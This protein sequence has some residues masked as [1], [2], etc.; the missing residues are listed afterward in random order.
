M[1]KNQRR[2][3]WICLSLAAVT[4]AVYGQALRCQF[5]TFDDQAYV[6]ENRH[7]LT[8]LT[9]ADIGWAFRSVTAG[10]WHPVTMLSHMLDCQIYGLRPWGHHLTSILLH[11][12]N[13]VL[14]F[15]L[16]ARMTGA[17]WPSACVAALFGV[18]PAHVESVAWVAERKDVLCAFFCLLA[19][20]AY[21]NA[22]TSSSKYRYGWVTALLALA[23]MSKPMAVTL[24]FVLLLLDYWPLERARGP[25]WPAWRRLATEKWPLLALSA[26][27]CGVT[28]WAQGHDK[29]VASEVELPLLGRLAHAMISY[30]NYARVLVFPWHLSAYYPYNRN[31]PLILGAAAAVALALVT[32]LSVAWAGKRPYLVVGW[33]WFLGMLVPVIGLVQVGGQGWADRY[34]Y[35]PS[36]GFFVIVIWGVME[37]AERLPAV[38]LLLPL[39][40]LALVMVTSFELRYWRDTRTLFGRAMEV[41]ENNY[42]AMTLAGSMDADSGK[43]DDAI[44]LYRRALEIK[45][46]YPEAHFFLGGALERKGQTAEALAEYNQALRLRKDFDAAHVMVGLLLTK[47]QKYSEAEAHYQVALESN[48]ESAAAQSDWGMALAK[49]GHWQESILHYEEALRLDPTLAE[50]HNNLGI[51][52]LQ[53]GR[54]ADGIKELRMTLKL[55]PG[56][57]ETEINLA[58][59]LNQEQQW[60][61]AAELLKPLALA[62]PSD[63][64]IQFQYG[65]SLEHLGQTRDAMSHYAAAL[66]KNPDYPEALQHLAWIAA[67]DAKPELRNGAQAV[68]LAAHACEIT[69]RKRPGMLLTLAAAYAEAGRFGEALAT[70]GKADELAKAQGQQEL[71]AQAGRL[72]ASLEAGHAFH[73]E[74]N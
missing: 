56:D 31:E 14:L 19:I 10:N 15:L 52:Y 35:L 71:Q 30:F 18:H 47:E 26:F 70:L 11:T 45:P 73:G 67:T 7:V 61:D 22:Q 13:T 46:T 65:L 53:T 72:R 48:P 5:L 36:I 74:S 24:P 8:G 44:R 3:V 41:T 51:D 2:K 59:A 66:L 33:L 23:L 21:L 12:A 57:A 34:V 39:F 54:L 20:W 17:V 1:N 6:T 4:L 38:K 16:L 60:D 63:F 28:V 9:L 37:C 62:H 58:Q 49:Q 64:N 68:E 69:G 25:D 50:A 32:L 29:A 55:N 43:L 40:G 42:L 27:W